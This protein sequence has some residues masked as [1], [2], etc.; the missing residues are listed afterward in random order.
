MFLK[1]VSTQQGWPNLV[2]KQVEPKN[3]TS[4]I[5]Q[6]RSF[7]RSHILEEHILRSPKS[8]CLFQSQQSH[9]ERIDEM[10]KNGQKA[11]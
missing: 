9:F 2:P 7:P 4:E 6:T 1:K 5:L 8:P 11:L 3:E 10:P